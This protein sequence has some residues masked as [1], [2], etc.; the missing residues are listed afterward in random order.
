MLAIWFQDFFFLYLVFVIPPLNDIE[1]GDFA[2]STI[3]FSISSSVGF[4]MVMISDDG[5]KT[6]LTFFWILPI[7]LLGTS[8]D[9]AHVGEIGPSD[10]I[11]TKNRERKTPK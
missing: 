7:S 2:T 4:A 5:G 6:P 1:V 3:S 10:W 8:L 11:N 9:C